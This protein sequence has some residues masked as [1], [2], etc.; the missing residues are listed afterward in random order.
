MIRKF[1]AAV[2]AHWNFQIPDAFK[3]GVVRRRP[4]QHQ[5]TASTLVIAYS[6]AG[7]FGFPADFGAEP[8]AGPTWTASPLCNVS[9]G[10]SITWSCGD[11]PAVTSTVSP[12]SRPSWI[13]LRATLPSPPRMATWVPRFA[14]ISA[15]AGRRTMFGSPGTWKSTRQYAPPYSLPSELS[16]C[17]S[18]SMLRVAWF[19]AFEMVTKVASNF[20]PGY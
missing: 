10:L 18:T 8:V 15:V 14:G 5:S 7:E 13:A 1:L 12:K 17:S 11:R 2:A 3:G 4:Q 9:G 6:V 20:W 16:A 19:R